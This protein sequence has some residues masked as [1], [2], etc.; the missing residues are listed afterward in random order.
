MKKILFVASLISAQYSFAQQS[1]GNYI[2]EVD[3]AQSYSELTGATNISSAMVWDNENFKF[4]LGFSVNI[5]GKAT[6]NFCFS[7]GQG[8]GPGSDTIGIV[9]TFSNFA[10]GD[11]VDR[12]LL[13]ATPKSPLRHMTSGVTPNRIFKFEVSNA[14]FKE[15]SYFYS[16]LNDS[17]NYQIWI[18]ETT[19][20]IEFRYGTSQVT[21]PS[22]YF[23]LG[24]SP[25]IGYSIDLNLSD[26]TF[27]KAYTLVGNSNSPTVDSFY[28]FS[29]L[30]PVMSSYPANGT[31]YRFIPKSVAASI[32]T[33]SL[34]AK[35]K[36]Y[37]T[38]TA[39]NITVIAEN[40]SATSGKFIDLNGRVI[41]VLPKIQQGKN[42]FDVS[43]L[44]AGSYLLEI[45]NSEG[46]AVYK[47]TKQ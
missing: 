39:D 1:I 44:A 19:G 12:G 23:F 2:L 9:N 21:H 27:S 3:T 42:I 4:P 46:R 28:D 16:T 36:V 30:P 7:S 18:Y 41:T 10:A 32:E 43:N 26:T 8:F 25:L 5:D 6:S 40:N 31:V 11:L 24:G 33:S 45:S 14:G 37:P 22:D 47:F 34:A 13:S 15:E 29:S 17:V 35:F 38:F 20:V